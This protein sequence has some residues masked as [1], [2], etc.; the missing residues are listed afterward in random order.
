[1]GRR[2]LVTGGSGYFGTLLVNY[3]HDRGDTVRCF[4]LLQPDGH[5][6]A[7]EFVQGDIRDREV[8]RAACEGIDV[9]YHN[10]AQVPLARDRELF[11]SVNVG[12][13]ATLLAAARD[14]AVTKIV[15]TSSSAVVG[16]P[17]RNPIGEDVVPRPKEPYGRAKLRAELLCRRAIEAGLDVTIIRPRTVLSSGRLGIASLLFDWVA[18]GAPIFVLGKGDNLFQFVH[19]RDLADAC[20]RAAERPGA[21]LYHAGAAEFGTMRE[22]LEALVRH[23]GT[24]STVLSLP[25]R[26]AVAAMKGLSLVGL[27]PFAPWHWLGYGESFW[28]D[29]SRAQNELGWQPKYSNVSMII[30][31]YEWFLAHRNDVGRSRASVHRSP[32]RQG[33]LRTLKAMGR[34]GLRLRGGVG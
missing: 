6:P 10:V 19:A 15:H 1:M 4:D 16:I 27:A 7:S 21:A 8:V 5:P 32:V 28:F 26:P 13:T 31:A 23:A 29:I 30:E 24:G 33:V 18:D 22:T 3:L 20:V 12:G 11:E 34:T 17:E 9:I 2:A 25:V 14:A